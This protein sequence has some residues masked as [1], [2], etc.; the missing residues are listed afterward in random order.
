MQNVAG[1]MP[2]R[3]C[4]DLYCA[5]GTQEVLPHAGEKGGGQCGSIVRSCELPTGLLQ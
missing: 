5:S 2:G 4:T 3:G 1:S